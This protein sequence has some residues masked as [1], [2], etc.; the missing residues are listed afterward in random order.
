MNYRCAQLAGA[1]ALI[2]LLSISP[3]LAQDVKSGPGIT[4]TSITVG[5]LSVLTGPVA[6]QGVPVANG[7]EAYFKHVNEDLKGINGRQILIAKQDHQYNAQNANQIFA[8]MQP[9]IAMFAELFGTPIIAALQRRL[10][11][12]GILAVPSTFG[13]Q[14]YADPLLVIPFA[15][16]TIQISGGID[17]LVKEKNGKSHELGHRFAPRRTGCRWRGGFRTC[18]EAPRSQGG[19][20]PDLRTDGHGFHGANSG[21]QRFRR[22]RHRARRYVRRSR[23]RSSSA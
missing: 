17:Y 11:D 22:Q 19:L 20:T 5:V 3:S 12:A 15:P 1:A 21:T 4:D 23:H 18:G 7:V 13:S 16:Y 10:G 2:A 9:R 6:L 14:F 8:Q